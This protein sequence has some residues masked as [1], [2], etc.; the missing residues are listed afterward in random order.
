MVAICMGDNVGDPYSYAK[1]HY[2][3]IRVFAPSLRVRA[4]IQSDSASYFLE[5]GLLL[6]DRGVPLLLLHRFLR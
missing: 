4:R 2:Y 1:F 5:M 3:P 6:F